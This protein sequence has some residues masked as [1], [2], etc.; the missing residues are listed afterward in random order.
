MRISSRAVRS[1]RSRQSQWTGF[2][3]KLWLV[4]TASTAS[5]M[6]FNR[7]SMAGGSWLIM[8]WFIVEPYTS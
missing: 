4:P 6:D 5:M 1:W 2:F 8:D 3:R 7:A